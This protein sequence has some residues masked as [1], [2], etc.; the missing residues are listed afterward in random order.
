MPTTH[1]I[2]VANETHGLAGNLVLPDH[3]SPESPVPGAVI[4]GGPGPVPL[5]RYTPEGEKQW[6][7]I[8]SEAL[9][10]EGFAG[11]CY[12]QRGSG[13]SSGLF[14][15]ADW[16]ALLEDARAAAEM[17]SVQPEVG[18]IAAIAWAEACPFALQLAVEGRVKALVLMAP[19]YQ[20]LEERYASG[21]RDLA[22][23]KGLSERVVQVRI[24]QWKNDLQ[25]TEQRV[26]RGEVITSTDLGGGN[27]IMTNLARFLKTATLDPAELV[28][29]VNI[30]VLL[31]HGE[32]D[33]V[34]PPTESQMMAQTL[35][36]KGDRITYPAVAHFVYRYSRVTTDAVGW[37]QH[38][39][40]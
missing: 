17:L 2:S 7:V 3:S 13:L 16:H 27:T 32:L 9:A 22:A 5:Q 36:P 39:L 20:K 38:V 37:L 34:I 23:R 18:P 40:G 14:H 1:P 11:L 30:P 4:L 6:P 35:G 8:W 24:E 25:A 19:A 10:A 15:E 21:I 29:Q 33:T 26:E 28:K 31:L 12:D